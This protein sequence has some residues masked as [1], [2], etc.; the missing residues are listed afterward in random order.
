MKKFRAIST[1]SLAIAL[2]AC[3]SYR[4]SSDGSEKFSYEL[5]EVKVSLM[6]SPRTPTSPR[7]IRIDL[8]KHDERLTTLYEQTWFV[9]NITRDEGAME[10]K[11]L[12]AKNQSSKSEKFIDK[13]LQT[14]SG[15][16][17]RVFPYPQLGDTYARMIGNTE[18]TCF[19]I[20]NLGVTDCVHELPNDHFLIWRSNWIANFT[21]LPPNELKEKVEKIER[22]IYIWSPPA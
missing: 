10:V 12:L 15:E 1:I 16:L 9:T 14:V 19:R 21:Q 13:V 4:S 8:N 18:W 11:L 17:R 20:H 3:A 7:T 5:S 6:A 22:S 2:S